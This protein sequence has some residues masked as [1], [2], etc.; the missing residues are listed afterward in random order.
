MFWMGVF[1]FFEEAS[2][3]V[4]QSLKNEWC[5]NLRADLLVRR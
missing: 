4:P 1:F 2:I 5:V 3:N